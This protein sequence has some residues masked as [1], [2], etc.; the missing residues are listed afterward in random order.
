MFIVDVR[1][2]KEVTSKEKILKSTGG[3]GKIPTTFYSVLKGTRK[4]SLAC[5]RVTSAQTY[6]DTCLKDVGES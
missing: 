3:G 6:S 5:L 2:Q 1:V 4:G